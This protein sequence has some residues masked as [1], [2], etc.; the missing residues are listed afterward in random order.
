MA[1]GDGRLRDARAHEVLECELHPRSDLERGR[2]QRIAETLDEHGPGV[3]VLL[4]RG[5]VDRI[6]EPGHPV[7]P[8]ERR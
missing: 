1:D 8:V 5:Q 7:E 3:A 4:A 2:G 6:V